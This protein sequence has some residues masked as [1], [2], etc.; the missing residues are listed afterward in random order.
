[1]IKRS[2]TN[3]G[4]S[5]SSGYSEYLDIGMDTTL[6]GNRYSSKTRDR[7]ATKSGGGSG[8][9]SHTKKRTHSE[10]GVSEYMKLET[11]RRFTE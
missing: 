9:Y 8:K 5:S 10:S 6:C 4:S 11:L 1:M 2:V 3:Y 7:D